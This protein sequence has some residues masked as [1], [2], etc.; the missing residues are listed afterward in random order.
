M[1]M[2]RRFALTGFTLMA[3][4]Y[5]SNAQYLTLDSYK[6]AFNDGTQL[7]TVTSAVPFLGISPDA[8]AGGMGDLGVATAP[9]ANSMHWNLAK[10]PFINRKTSVSLSYSP[11]LRNLIPD[12]NL[13]YLSFGQKIGRMGA[14]SASLRY[15][16]LGQI[17][18]TDI[19]GGTIG[20]YNPNEFSLDAGYAMKF[21]EYWSMG[22]AF[23]FIYS[24]LTLGQMV[25]G[26][27]TF[28][29]K[30]G[31]GDIT[32]FYQNSDWKIA[33]KD[34][35]FRFG[36][37]FTNLGSKIRYSATSRADFLPMNFR[38]GPSLTM[39]FDDYNSLMWS[40]EIN[41]MLVPTM[42]VYKIDSVTNQPIFNPDGT[43]VLLG[44]MDPNRSVVNAIFTS[45]ADAPGGFREELAEYNI[46]TGLEYW[47]SDVFSMR[48][49]YFNEDKRK[50]NRKYFTLGAGVRYSAFGL[51]FS[52][53]VPVVQRN[54]LENTIRFSL[55]FEFDKLKKSDNPNDKPLPGR[56]RKNS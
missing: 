1:N 33:K 54:P 55:T 31:A 17:T 48:A 35:I 43:P 52:Y 7:N 29:G 25:G 8:R 36:L 20:N 56:R 4:F 14:L 16:S 12:V 21:N 19:T 9:D 26:A 40:F 51:D 5:L 18:F 42:P 38:F 49:G 34:V 6:N 10:L 23:R 15:F 22:V 28:P 46:S 11:W 44:G 53:L 13:A 37:A 2:I 27:S 30:A 45:F 24:N 41:K 50:G 32:L 39:K 3:G 47:Y